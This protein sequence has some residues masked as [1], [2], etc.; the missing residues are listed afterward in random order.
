[1]NFK[2]PLLGV[3]A[4]AIALSAVTVT[5]SPAQAAIVAGSALNLASPINGGVSTSSTLI[6]FSGTFPIVQNVAVTTGSNSFSFAPLGLGVS[7][8][9]ARI[10]DVTLSGGVFN[11]SLTNFISGITT[12]GFGSANAVSFDL[13]QFIFDNVEKKGDFSGVI[14]KGTDLSAAIGQFTTQEISGATS[15][16]LTLTAVPTPALLPGL[17]G[18]GMG[19]LRKRKK[20]MAEGVGAEA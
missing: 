1:M 20:E 7:N 13:T 2:T 17:I 8:L 15:Y 16:S 12:T 19:V 10:R 9:T 11:G 4:A 3:A 6:N 18:L 14:R 5:S